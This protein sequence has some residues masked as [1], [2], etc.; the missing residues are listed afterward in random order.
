[1]SRNIYVKNDHAYATFVV[2]T[3]PPFLHLWHI[4]K[5]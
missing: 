5:F 3:I 2:I 1:M 4:T